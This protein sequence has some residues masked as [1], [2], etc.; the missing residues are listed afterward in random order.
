MLPHPSMT[1]SHPAGR[2]R[3]RL[4]CGC[5]LVYFPGMIRFAAILLGLLVSACSSAAVPATAQDPD[6]APER[7][8][9]TV[10]VSADATVLRAPDRAVVRLGV[11]STARTAQGATA[12][13]AEAMTAVVDALEG[14]GIPPAAIRTEAISLSPRYERGGGEPTIIGYQ[15]SNRVSVRVAAIDRLGRVVD[16]AIGAGANRVEGIEFGITDTEAAYHEALERAVAKARREAESLA[17]ALGE[18]LGPPIR[19]ST[20]GVRAPATQGPMSE[21]LRAQATVTPVQPGEL[22]VR[23]V[24]HITYRLGS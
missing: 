20:G 24:V 4:A 14:A 16:A 10:D 22:E 12:A 5:R 23:A 18:T 21:M 2:A 9:R 15:A 1:L 19:V 7:P 6:P 3:P 17:R 8:Y 13:N 11:E